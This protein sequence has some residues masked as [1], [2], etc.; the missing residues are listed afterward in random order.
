MFYPWGKVVKDGYI[1]KISSVGYINLSII[2]ENQFNIGYKSLPD[3]CHAF[4]SWATLLSPSQAPYTYWILDKLYSCVVYWINLLWVPGDRHHIPVWDMY[5]WNSIRAKSMIQCLVSSTYLIRTVSYCI[6]CMREEN[7]G[8]VV[9]Q[10]V[11]WS[12]YND[13]LC[14]DSVSQRVNEI[15]SNWKVH[16]FLILLAILIQLLLSLNV[17]IFCLALCKKIFCLQKTVFNAGYHEFIF[18][19]MY[20][21]YPYT[22]SHRVHFLLLSGRTL[23][24]CVRPSK[25]D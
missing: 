15:I 3:V 10:T 13:C 5:G 4:L 2:P 6:A 18:S 20:K 21:V 9:S 12:C 22:P 17:I 24:F 1:H 25:F 11:Q 8:T 19:N 16:C 7:S 14:N 23:W